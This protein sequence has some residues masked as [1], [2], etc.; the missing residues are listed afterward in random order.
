[1][2]LISLLIYNSHYYIFPY[3]EWADG[4]KKEKVKGL[5]LKDT[6]ALKDFLSDVF[7][8]VSKSKWQT[9]DDLSDDEG[10]GLVTNGENLETGLDNE[11]DRFL[12]IYLFMY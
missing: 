6:L 4:Y 1:M 7:K 10:K 5:A 8:M 3:H 9:N 11:F 2:N 12:F